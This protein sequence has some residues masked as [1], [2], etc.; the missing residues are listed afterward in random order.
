M[1]IRGDT[2][3]SCDA[4]GIVKLWDVWVVSEYL[5]IDTGQHP[6]NAA[7]FDRSG[8]VLAIASGDASIKTFN[9]E[10][11]VFVANLEGHDDSVQD[12]AF[13][14]TGDK[15]LLSASSDASFACGSDQPYLRT[16]LRTYLSSDYCL[17]PSLCTCSL[18][19][20]AA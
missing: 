20:W 18:A 6:A 2:I 8:K 3:A 12:V 1:G 15:Y 7:C 9:V 14:P 17:L 5:Q 19:L 16:H 11:R 13:E 10:E 4:D